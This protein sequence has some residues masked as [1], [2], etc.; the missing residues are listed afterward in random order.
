MKKARHLGGGPDWV[1]ALAAGG[2][3]GTR[4]CKSGGSLLGLAEHRH[5]F[6]HGDQPGR[7][8]PGDPR[9]AY[10]QAGGTGRL[11]DHS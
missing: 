6:V 10:S 4:L 2:G 9:A 3:S 11:V 7:M 5:G 8:N 1:E